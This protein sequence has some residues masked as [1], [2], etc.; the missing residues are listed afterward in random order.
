MLMQ[1]QG[2]GPGGRRAPCVG[3]VMSAGWDGELS[4][5]HPGV[6]H[7]GSGLVGPGPL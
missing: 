3:Q 5:G 7:G 1:T 2:R 4:L 6:C